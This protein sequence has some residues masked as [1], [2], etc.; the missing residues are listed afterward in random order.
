MEYIIRNNNEG[1]IIIENKNLLNHETGHHN[2]RYKSN[3]LPHKCH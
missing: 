1:E 3:N 2:G